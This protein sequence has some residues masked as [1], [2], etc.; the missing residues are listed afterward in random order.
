LI[1]ERRN[2]IIDSP[3]EDTEDADMT[4]LPLVQQLAALNR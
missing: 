3:E 1:V 4:E 2:L